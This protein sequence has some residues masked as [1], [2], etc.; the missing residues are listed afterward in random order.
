M[1]DTTHTVLLTFKAIASANVIFIIG[2]FAP[3]QVYWINMNGTRLCEVESNSMGTI[4][5]D[6][7]DWSYKILQVVV[8]Q[9]SPVVSPHGGG[10]AP[11]QYYPTGEGLPNGSEGEFPYLLWIFI[12]A[13]LSAL[14]LILFVFLR[15]K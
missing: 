6:N 13:M 9:E 3:N 14:M 12:I 7:D 8:G 11:T 10:N 15:K 2:G 1:I 5:F 4:Q